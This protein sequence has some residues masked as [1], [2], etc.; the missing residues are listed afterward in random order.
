[1]IFNI[2]KNIVKNGNIISRKKP[3]FENHVRYMKNKRRGLKEQP[4]KKPLDIEKKIKNPD[5]YE[6]KMHFDNL[7]KGE[8]YL[9]ES[10]KARK[11]AMLCNRLF[12]FNINDEELLERYAQRAIVIANSMGT[13]EISLILNTMRKFNHKNEKLLETFAK[14]IPS[15]L[16][17]GVP[18]DISLILNAYAHFNYIDKNLFNRICEEIPH[19]IPYFEHNHI[20]SVINAFYKLKI[21]DKIIIDDMA[22]EIIERINEFDTK[23]LTNIINSFSKL[24]YKNENKKIIW[25]KFIEAV[26][27]LNKEFNFLEVVLITNAF[28][29]KKMKN[30]NIYSFLKEILIYHIFERKSLNSNNAFLLCTAA[31]SFACIKFYSKELFDFII[32]YFSDENNYIS[33]DTQHFSQLIYPCSVFNIKNPLFVD[34]FIK[35][36]CKKIENKELNEQTISTIAYSLAKLNIRD[37]NFFVLLSSYIIKEKIN[38]STQSLSLICYSYSKLKIKSEILFYF[39]S[40]QIFQSMNMLTKQGLSIILNSYANLKI[41]NVKLFTLINKYLNLYADNFTNEE[42]LLICKNY[43]NALKNMNDEIQNKNSDKNVV[44]RISNTKKELSSFVNTLKEKIE[45]FKKHGDLRS[46]ISLKD[47]D[48]FSWKNKIHKNH[49]TEGEEKVED[50]MDEENEENFFS[51]FNQNDIITDEPK[52][53]SEEF[54]YLINSDKLSDTFDDTQDVKKKEDT[55][56]IYE[57]MFLN[58][59]ENTDNKKISL[60]NEELNKNLHS[61]LDNE[62]KKI[63]K[64]KISENRSAK[65]LI[66]LMTSN[67]PPIINYDKENL[68]KSAEQIE[69]EFIKAYINEK[70]ESN[71]NNKIGRSSKRRKKKVDK[72][73]SKKYEPIEDINTL[74]KK[75]NN[76]YEK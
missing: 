13:K 46:N 63:D 75:W 26:K 56:K 16:Y 4:R 6:E 47:D 53:K 73:L 8:L 18:Q 60:M 19:K 3:I 74:Q 23:S 52:D 54:N 21:K 68:I 59:V 50:E 71:D 62:S 69:T 2:F 48:H 28:C 65:S 33:L 17:K 27:N 35:M 51:I 49:K 58:N 72:I 37:T 20:S 7:C 31:H 70:N 22:D 64:N 5:K 39:L 41:F 55:L 43:E 1:M 76:F 38:L 66:E 40:I 32:S 30:K 29:K 44:T 11:L 25:E 10:C 57:K 61:I 14:Y 24:N 9:P 12:Y 36:S 34:V 45:Y 67:K 42:C 15:K